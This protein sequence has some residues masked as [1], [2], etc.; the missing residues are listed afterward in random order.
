MFP[1]DPN[2]GNV[3]NPPSTAIPIPSVS[4]VLKEEI[5]IRGGEIKT[6]GTGEFIASGA[7][8]YDSSFSI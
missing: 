7:M 4:G 8:P 6:T 3:F 1:I 2:K 5:P